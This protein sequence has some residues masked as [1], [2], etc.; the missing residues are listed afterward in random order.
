MTKEDMAENWVREFATQLPG[1]FD[2]S[3]GVKCYLAGL[4]DGMEHAAQI[5][6]AKAFDCQCSHWIREEGL[7]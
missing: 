5:S 7:K 2:H 6:D 3:E 1:S 4:K